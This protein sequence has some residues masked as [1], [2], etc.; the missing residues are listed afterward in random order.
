MRIVGNPLGLVFHDQ[1]F[2]QALIVSRDPGRAGIPVTLQRLDATQGKHETPCRH[3]EI[4]AHAQGPG[5]AARG[6][7]LAR[8]NDPDVIPQIVLRERIDHHR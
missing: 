4:R 3:R 7:Q 2:L 8:G 6:D 1:A 5:H